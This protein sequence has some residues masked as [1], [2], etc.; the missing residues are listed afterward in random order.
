LIIHEFLNI[1]LQKNIIKK[2]KSFINYLVVTDKMRLNYAQNMYDAATASGSPNEMILPNQMIKKKDFRNKP[3]SS[4]TGHEISDLLGINPFEGS[5][6]QSTTST[7]LLYIKMQTQTSS[8]DSAFQNPLRFNEQP[9]YQRP[10]Y[11]NRTSNLED[12][13]KKYKMGQ[14][15]ILKDKIGEQHLFPNISDYVNVKR[16]DKSLPSGTT[17]KSSQKVYIPFVESAHYNE[18]PH[19]A[20]SGIAYLN[21]LNKNI[22]SLF[23][24][25]NEG[26]I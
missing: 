10:N 14:C 23:K 5:Q 7:F 6:N 2:N 13:T 21:E 24:T 11:S 4:D 22:C 26:G 25:G 20:K 15:P 18:A 19:C 8:G 9:N 12:T 3:I 16:I 1:L 17:S